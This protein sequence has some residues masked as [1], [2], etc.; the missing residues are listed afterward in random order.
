MSKSKA[1]NP[2]F[3]MTNRG[4]ASV[5][6]ALSSARVGAVCVPVASDGWLT[7][8]PE[9]AKNV[10]NSHVFIKN[11]SEALPFTQLFLHLQREY[12]G[13]SC[14]ASPYGCSAV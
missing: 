11:T 13:L 14:S 2:L 1:I 9:L 4:S 3:F 5:S 8:S 6:A 12:Y 10:K 7:G